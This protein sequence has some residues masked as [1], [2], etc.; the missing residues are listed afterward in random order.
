MDDILKNLQEI[1][2]ILPHHSIRIHSFQ[3]ACNNGGSFFLGQSPSTAA[4]VFLAR[5]KAD[6]EEIIC[7]VHI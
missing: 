2:D 6:F 3:K 1:C 7:Q 5:E 4:A